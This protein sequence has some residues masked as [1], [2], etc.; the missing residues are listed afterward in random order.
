MQFAGRYFAVMPQQEV[1]HR[2]RDGR[3]RRDCG[4]VQF[5][6]STHLEIFHSLSSAK[7]G[8]AFLALRLQPPAKKKNRTLAFGFLMNQMLV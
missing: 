8:G 1:T 3:R 2:S 5:P 4:A 7:T 6:L